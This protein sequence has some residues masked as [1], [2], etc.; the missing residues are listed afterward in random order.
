MWINVSRQPNVDVVIRPEDVKV[1]PA[2]EGMLDGIVRSSFKGV[3]YEMM[4]EG[5]GFAWMVHS[6]IMPVD[7]KVGLRVDPNDIHIMRKEAAT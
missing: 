3:H 4:I 6:T 7:S 1:V 2:G 5:Q